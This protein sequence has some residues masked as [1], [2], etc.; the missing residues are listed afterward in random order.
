MNCSLL[1][2]FFLLRNVHLFHQ[3]ATSSIITSSL[4]IIAVKAQTSVMSIIIIGCVAKFTK[5]PRT[6]F[7]SYYTTFTTR[8]SIAIVALC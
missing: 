5:C 1:C 7:T 4:I 2:I 8:Q 3:I 6:I